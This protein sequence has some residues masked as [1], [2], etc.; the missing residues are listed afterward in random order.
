MKNFFKN[1][2][3]YILR[4]L[5]ARR[6]KK[7]KGKIVCVTGS[8]GKT[9][10]KEAIFCVLNAR[11]KVK[12]SEK[13]MNTDFGMLLTILDI[14]SGYSSATRWA[15]LLFRAFFHS[16]YTDTSDVLLLE[17]GVD[18]PGDM[19]YLT[20]I[21]KPDV[22]IMTNVAPVHLA[23][24]QFK[25]TKGI[26]DEKSKLISALKDGGVAILNIDDPFIDALP[27]KCK[28]K[29]V[30]TYAKDSEA[31]FK[32]E[33][34]SFDENGLRFLIKHEKKVYEVRAPILGER[35]AYVLLP[36]FICGM[37]W[38]IPAEDVLA[39]LAKFVL[40][41][42]RMSVIKGIEDITILD[43]SY[44]SSP[45]ALKEALKVLKHV[46]GS[47]RKVA[48]L[49]NM[50]ELGEESKTLH[51]K[52]GEVVPGYAD[53]LITVG[54][55]AALIADKALELGVKEG[56]V[57][58]VKSALEAVDLYKKHL[59]KNDV[60]LVKGSQNNVRLEKF[61]REFMSNPENANK[62]LVR[63]EKL[64]LKKR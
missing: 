13:S 34:I 23:E 3:L 17:M 32:A 21:V 62:L 47:R 57:F 18:K 6:L 31:D 14:D 49:G 58:K 4:R 35:Q 20:K 22:A 43:S 63:Q 12:C 53:V 30:I 50:N 46:A 42:G 29:K 38:E 48:V 36:A 9:S 59:K 45:E 27:K 8:I 41:P 1:V 15:W 28:K 56:H 60:V 2:V 19:D 39:S 51:E 25:D 44:N 33:D 61:V 52:I 55:S 24:G 54:A 64:W 7:F 10:T 40:P 26:F 11:L 16:F 5:T 37:L